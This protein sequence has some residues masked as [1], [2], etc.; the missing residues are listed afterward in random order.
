M[1][2]TL[3]NKW[4]S[5]YSLIIFSVVV[6]F[7]FGQWVSN[8]ELNTK[9]V[10][11]VLNPVN[12]SAV[13]DGSGG[14]FVFWQ[15]AKND[16]EKRVYFIHFEN[17]ASI[18]F[19]TDGKRVTSKKGQQVKPVVK[20]C[21][22]GKA[23]VLWLGTDETG[24]SDLYVQ[25]L[26]PNGSLL[27][28]KTGIKITNTDDDVSDYSLAVDRLGN[29]YV[30]Y[31]SKEPGFLGDFKV[32]L[33]KINFDGT[34]DSA[35]VLIH[36]T[37]NRMSTTQIITDKD[38]GVFVFWME[39][40]KG[41]SIL[42][43][44]HLDWKLKTSGNQGLLVSLTN[45]SVSN[46]SI[47]S[48]G[49]NQA[50]VCWQYKSNKKEI[51]QSL[52]SDKLESLWSK[53]PVLVVDNLSEKKDVRLFA[54]GDNFWSCWTSDSSGSKSVFIKNYDSKGKA[55]PFKQNKLNT[56]RLD[57]SF[58][59]AIISDETGGVIVSW[60]SNKPGSTSPIIFAQRISSTGELLWDKNSIT[61]S[62]SDHSVKSNLSIIP[63]LNGG[64]FVVF[65]DVRNRKPGIYAQRIFS[66][67]TYVSQIV[68]FNAELVKDSVHISWYSAN[69]S[70]SSYYILEKMN[71]L[72]TSST[73]WLAIDT[74]FTAGEGHLTSY[75][76]YDEPENAGTYYYRLSH[77]DALGNSQF[78]DVA[79]INYIIDSEDI[80]V[81]QNDPNPFSDS[82]RISFYV[83][84]TIYVKVEFF[85]SSIQKID[86]IKRMK[87]KAGRHD[88]LFLRNDLEA[89]IYFYRVTAG[90]FV[91][92]KKMVI[93]KN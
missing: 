66:N 70:D 33:K 63:D 65:K 14:G 88:I 2:K 67:G 57:N 59:P 35:N 15:D 5:L 52:I 27:W 93:A 39:N 55:I 28:T 82:T 90:N 71:Y 62:S 3:R 80:I 25:K 49:K 40:I 51:N 22:D 85:N 17:D 6:P 44:Q 69:E 24:K 41:K 42:M 8:P 89:G 74:L 36:R 21:S 18:S 32:M 38:I 58:S 16:G 86:E 23:V 92:V 37:N 77:N 31:L 1:M 68:G 4:T 9:I 7:S 83:P 20:Y 45:K 72:D 53:N 19:R 56:F 47:Q 73:N 91:E 54:A 46:Y 64:S 79:R 81:A 60:F 43:C 78:S 84:K 87:Y 13:T 34:P 76:Y 12:L 29:L 48:F 50:Y 10:S 75:D 26:A 30:S 11:D 61:V